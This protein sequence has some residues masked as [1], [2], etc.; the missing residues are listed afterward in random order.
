MARRVSFGYVA[1]RAPLAR[2]ESMSD[3]IPL[4]PDNFVRATERAG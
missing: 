3:T 4:E 2:N 1:V